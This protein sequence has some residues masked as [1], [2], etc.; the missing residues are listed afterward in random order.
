MAEPEQVETPLLVLP[1]HQNGVNDIL[2]KAVSS[3]PDQLLVIGC[4]DDNGVSVSLIE[5]TGGTKAVSKWST[6]IKSAHAAAVT[7]EL[8]D[9]PRRLLIYVR[10]GRWRRTQVLHDLL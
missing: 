2:V 1:V 5:V 7:G 9:M 4:G 8:V 10:L 6:S 3:S